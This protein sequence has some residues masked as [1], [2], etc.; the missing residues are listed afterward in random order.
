MVAKNTFFYI[1][2]STIFKHILIAY[3]N[4]PRVFIGLPS[5][6]EAWCILFPS[7][8]IP[9]YINSPAYLNVN[10][11]LLYEH[12]PSLRKVVREVSIIR[13]STLNHLHYPLQCA[14]L[15]LGTIYGCSLKGPPSRQILRDTFHIKSKTI[16]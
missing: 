7:S 13:P 1:P 10:V 9:Y 12:G 3:L 6:H 8:M 14:L 4:N 2:Y 5:K 11:Y 16:L 15:I